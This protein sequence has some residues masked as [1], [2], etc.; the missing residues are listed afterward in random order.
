MCLDLELWSQRIGL[1][2]RGLFDLLLQGTAMWE[3]SWGCKLMI[4]EAFRAVPA[5][6]KNE[7]HF[8]LV[9]RLAPIQVC[10]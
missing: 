9:F 1:D 7:D 8:F 6:K 2:D 10:R 3:F 4:V 5:Q